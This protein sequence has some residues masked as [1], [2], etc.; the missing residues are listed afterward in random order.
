MI[1]L[2]NIAL[3]AAV[4][5]AVGGRAVT[6][7]PLPV[8]SAQFPVAAEPGPAGGSVI[9]SLATPFSVPGSF[10]GTLM[11]DVISGDASNPLGG[12]TFVYSLV[13]SVGPNSIGRFSVDGYLGF[14]TDVSYDSTSGGKAPAFADR[15]PFGDVIGFSFLP[16]PVDPNT[17]FLTPGSL[18]R[19]MVIQTDA[20]R[21]HSV[22]GSLIDGGVVVAAA[23][24]PQVPEP[25]TIVLAG[26]GGLAALGYARRRRV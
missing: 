13:N 23:L 24:G 18:S 20:T 12:L 14:V 2:W 11:T 25:A 17:G 26:L 15:N 9:A 8:G 21:Y 7:A 4:L 19:R 5:A 6:A 10:T 1:R 3:A 16:S 22:Q